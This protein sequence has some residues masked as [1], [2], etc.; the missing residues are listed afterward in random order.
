M[1][2]GRASRT[3]N[4]VLALYEEQEELCLGLRMGPT[5]PRRALAS[6]ISWEECPI[7]ALLSRLGGPLER[8]GK[9]TVAAQSYPTA[10][11][12]PQ[13]REEHAF[14]SVPTTCTTLYNHS[15]YNLQI[16]HSSGRMFPTSGSPW[17]GRTDRGVRAAQSQ[18]SLA[19]DASGW[20]TCPLSLSAPTTS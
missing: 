6:A 16:P 7:W 14:H 20:P 8:R 3:G 4:E 9:G 1:G 18:G 5:T 12:L 15:T 19:K 17:K 10:Q 13:L 11:A 2:L